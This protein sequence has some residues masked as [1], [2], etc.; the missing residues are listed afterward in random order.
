MPRELKPDG[1][2]G[3]AAEPEPEESLVEFFRNSPLAEA[4]AAGE[5]PSDAFERQ[6]D[7]PRDVDL[8]DL[9]PPG[10]A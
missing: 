2:I 3:D 4:I 5:L 9:E 8:S 1:P 10:S 6:R 7:L